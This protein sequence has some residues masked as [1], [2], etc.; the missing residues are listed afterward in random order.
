LEDLIAG[1]I[2]AGDAS[3]EVW[4]VG[5]VT[6]GGEEDVDGFVYSWVGGLVESI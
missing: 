6:R 3:V 4:S 2:V 5:G 1:E